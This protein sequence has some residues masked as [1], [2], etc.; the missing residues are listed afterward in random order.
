MYLLGVA[1]FRLHPLDEALSM[2]DGLSVDTF[3]RL[4]WIF[5]A[6]DSNVGPRES[7]AANRL[8]S[9][10]EASALCCRAYDQLIR[11]IESKRHATGAAIHRAALEALR[12]DCGSLADVQ[13]VESICSRLIG[14]RVCDR[15]RSPRRNER[16]LL[17]FD[18]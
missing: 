9:T 5:G 1:H 11:V 4:L 7:H 10:N 18:E 12:L 8:L 14:K 2:F 13:L 3:A 15:N 6:V 17:L 16:Q